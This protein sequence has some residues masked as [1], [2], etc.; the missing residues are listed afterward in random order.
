MSSG[1]PP[2]GSLRQSPR[3]LL[4]L[5]G[6]TLALLATFGLLAASFIHVSDA[7][8]HSWQDSQQAAVQAEAARIGAS[9]GVLSAAATGV[10]LSHASPEESEAWL[11]EQATRYADLV[12]GLQLLAQDHEGHVLASTNDQLAT[13]G[14]Q[15]PIGHF[16]EACPVCAK[17]NWL[18]VTAKPDAQGRVVSAALP[19]QDLSDQ[20]QSPPAWLVGPDGRIL[21]HHDDAQTGTRPFD[22]TRDDPSLTQML[23]RMAAGAGGRAQYGWRV[24]ETNEWQP[25]LASFAPVPGAPHGWSLATSAPA[26]DALKEVR[27]AL[28]LLGL[29]TVGQAAVGGLFTLMMV[30]F[31]RR[32]R[33]KE[34]SIAAERLTMTRA[35]AHADRLALIGTM[36]AGVAHDL[37][38]PL[39]TLRINLEMM[40]EI[41]DPEEAQSLREDLSI[42][43]EQLIRLSADLT[44]Y[45][46]SGEDGPATSQPADALNTAVRILAPVLRTRTTVDGDL[47]GLPEV[48][49]GTQRLGQ[50]LMNLVQ[51]ASLMASHVHVTGGVS[52]GAVWIHVEDD[53][54]GIAD[55]IAGT[56]F[57]PFVTTRAAGEGT[58]LGL[59]LCRRFIE[60]A[61]GSITVGWSEELGGARFRIVLPMVTGAAATPGPTA[62]EDGVE[63]ARASA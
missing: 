2:P 29:A 19:L 57:E 50:V 36:T 27:G 6:V 18:V 61:G 24:P 41:D 26:D 38:S 28:R 16:G 33:R 11:A 42:A 35:A 25:R 55:N 47:A 52:D 9:I 40:D 51:N 44:R 58:G 53:G 21:A 14:H 8:V 54:P 13:V 32:T 37:R 23:E 3:V 17:S 10:R 56:L 7:A 46:R 31:Q 48:T 5:A 63:P 1:S 22:P 62:G 20:L 43:M 39:T 30:I 4:V 60:E 59:Y 45:S 49:C 34:E 12:D 15:H